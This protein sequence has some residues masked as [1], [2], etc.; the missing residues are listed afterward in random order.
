MEIDIQEVLAIFTEETAEGLQAMEE[1]VVALE[2]R[3][4]DREAVDTVFRVTHTLKGNAGS[5]G[6]PA[7]ADFAH[8]LEDLLDRIRKGRLEV[9]PPLVSL[10]LQA[11]DALKEM[12]PEAVAGAEQLR[13]THLELLARLRAGDRKSVV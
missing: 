9:T 4:R 11:V 2:A 13:P 1:A 6:F 10:L 12:V 5:L 7:V 3:P 8:V